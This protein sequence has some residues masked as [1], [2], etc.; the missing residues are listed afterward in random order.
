VDEGGSGGFSLNRC[1]IRQMKAVQFRGFAGACG[2][3]A[4]IILASNASIGI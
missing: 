3:V 4:G 1:S 2:F